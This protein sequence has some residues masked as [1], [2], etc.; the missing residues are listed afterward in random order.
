VL[1][2]NDLAHSLG[3]SPGVRCAGLTPLVPVVEHNH[4]RREQG[5]P[6]AV[7]EISEASGQ[8]V[9]SYWIPVADTDDLTVHFGI[10]VLNAVAAES[11]RFR[12][13]VPDVCNKPCAAPSFQAG[14]SSR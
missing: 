1:A 12:K 3:I 14:G 6:T 8:P 5:T 10:G 9:P 7:V 4:A 11:A 13:L 2:V